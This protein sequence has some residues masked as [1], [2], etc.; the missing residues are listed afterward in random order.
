M[1]KW[2]QVT[3]NFL[4]VFSLPVSLFAS[5]TVLLEFG[6]EDCVHC[7]QVEPLVKQL[8]RQGHP[9][10]QLDAYQNVALAQKFDV[11]G[12]PTF[13]MLVDGNIADRHTG[14]AEIPIMETRLMQMLKLGQQ[15]NHFENQS[16][17][18]NTIPPQNPLPIQQVRAVIP[19]NSVQTLPIPQW[20]SEPVIPPSP[21]M[22]FPETNVPSAPT[23][24][25]N[26]LPSACDHPFLKA[27]VRLRVDTANA[28]D[29]GT[30]T[31]IDVRNGAALILT[32]GHIFRHSG[33]TGQ[34]EVT[35][36]SENSQKKIQGKLIQYDEQFD[37]AFV[38][39]QPQFPVTAVPLA[40][41]D[42]LPQ[43]ND[44]VTSVGC[45]GGGV[46]TLKQHRILS[47]RKILST[48]T[49]SFHY[50]QVDNPPVQGRSGGGLFS[51]SGYLIGVCS[52]ADP[53]EGYFTPIS[54][55][56][57]EM[58]KRS[59]LAVVIRHPVITPSSQMA[60][61]PPTAIPDSMVSSVSEPPLPLRLPESP[62]SAELSPIEQASLDQIKRYRQDG[63]EIICII[64]S[65]RDPNGPSDIIQLQSASPEFV[66]ALRELP[67]PVSE[68]REFV[69]PSSLQKGVR[70]PTALSVPH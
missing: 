34:I 18:Q 2:H 31:I 49:P 54:V 55:I 65:K 17:N 44:I 10:R 48:T 61:L 60:S 6:A 36:F 11:T 33:G 29:W 22:G 1:L 3:L 30:G 9:I 13:I 45:D 62:L 52:A 58:N 63:A 14:T 42:V 28:H 68:E 23:P 7:Q 27:T 24:L 5:E 69:S 26:F 15:H 56:G 41:S 57:R 53:Q 43:E 20:M 39:I 16:L 66:N 35:L 4:A 64:K 67:V 46:P 70:V 59:D 21:A 19:Q 47:L 25:K 40:V 51:K 37:I 50:V 32:C 8:I 12:L 38:V